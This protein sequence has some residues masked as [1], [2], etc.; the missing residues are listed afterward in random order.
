MMDA[1]EK[2]LIRPSRHLYSLKDLGPARFLIGD[3]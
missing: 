1:L 2:L 3:R